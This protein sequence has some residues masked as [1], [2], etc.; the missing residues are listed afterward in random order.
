MRKSKELYPEEKW[1][2]RNIIGETY[3]LYK[4]HDVVIEVKSR[5]SN[6]IYELLKNSNQYE[7]PFNPDKLFPE[8][9]ILDKKE[10]VMDSKQS[11]LLIPVKGG[12]KMKINSTHS[13]NRKRF[14]T[15]HEIGHTY[16][17]DLTA[18]TPCKRYQRTSSTYMIEEDYASSFAA[19][20]LMPK[21]FLSKIIQ[22]RNLQPSFR[23]LKI[24]QRMFVVSFESIC[25]QT[26]RNHRLLDCL[27]F[28]ST[29]SETGRITNLSQTICKGDSFKNWTV[30]KTFESIDL[31]DKKSD[32]FKVTLYELLSKLFNKLIAKPSS[33]EKSI[34]YKENVYSIKSQIINDYTKNRCITIIKKI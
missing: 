32:V 9:K 3:E 13:Y 21:P 29:L 19:E 31:N 16:F 18:E 15:A 14:T 34:C 5:I 28:E 11:G 4:L 7:P 1:L 12:F 10:D 23:T 27:I 2:A 20:I 33:I 22:E 26:I 6:N 8:R 25:K 24:L 30:P 17:Y